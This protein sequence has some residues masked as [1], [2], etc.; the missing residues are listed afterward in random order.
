MTHVHMNF[1]VHIETVN[2]NEDI[3][4][5][6]VNN[7]DDDLSEISSDICSSDDEMPREYWDGG[8]DNEIMTDFFDD[9]DEVESAQQLGE[10]GNILQT[11]L[12]FF[13]LWASFYG[14]SATA[15]NHLIKFLHYVLSILMKNM[16]TASTF[17]TSF[18]TS[19]YMMKKYLGFS[20]DTFEK[21]VICEKC[22]S[23]YTFKEC[24]VTNSAGTCKPKA[25]N[26]IAFRN[27][28][29]PSCREPCGH[30]LLKEAT[31]RNDVKYYPRKTYCFN[32][33]QNSLINILNRKGYL[34]LCEHWRSRNICDSVLADIY[35]GCIWKEWMVYN[36]RP[37][38]ACP[39]N[40]AVMLNCDW[41]QPFDH[42]CY[43]VGVLYLVI[44]NLP[45]SLRFKPENIIITGV[46]PGPKEPNQ[47][48]MNSCLRPI[49][50]ELNALFTE[51]F[52]IEQGSK[53]H[54]IFVALIAT[55]CDLP[56]TAKLGGFLNHNSHYGCWKCC[57]FFPYVEELKRNDYSGLAVGLPR[58]HV[59]HKN[60]AKGTLLART[61]TERKKKELDVGG[62]FTE[63]FHLPY[64]NTVRYAII[65]P[66]HNLF[67]G[68][69]KRLQHYWIRMGLL[70]SCNLK[71]V[72]ERVDN[73]NTPSNIGHMP[74]KIASGFSNMTA[75][76][77]KNW[78][79]LYSVIALHD[80]LPPQHMACWQLFVSACTILCSPII[81][82]SEIDHVQQLLYEFFISVERLDSYNVTINT[83]LHL[84]YSQCLKD[85][86]PCY[87]YWL[88]S[89]ERYN[90][91]LGKYHTNRKS[92]ETQLMQTF[93]N[94]MYAKSLADDINPLHQ[95]VFENLLTS[96][97]VGAFNETVYGQEEFSASHMLKFSE[98]PV[99]PSLSYL[100]RSFIKLIPPYIIQKIENYS[101][102]YLRESYQIFLPE[103]DPFEIPQFIRRY[104]VVHWW[105][106]CLGKPKY[107]KKRDQII[108][109]FWIG[110]DG[111]I[112]V[113]AQ[114][115]CTGKVEYF[116]TQNI[117]I[118][119]SYQLV[120]MA[121]IKWLQDH[122]EKSRLP[123]PVEIWCNEMFKPHGP[124]SFMPIVRI[125]DTCVSC[126]IEINNEMVLAINPCRS[127]IF[128]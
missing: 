70:N 126:E 101:L 108:R 6:D 50:K 31:L 35:D 106:Q 123:E 110:Q 12:V 74:G 118:E 95:S 52:V 109:A 5:V 97:V 125:Y 128:L 43:S 99:T 92:I 83:H 17:F 47:A 104:E 100:D 8:S 61:P 78:T 48:M 73:F 7:D 127:K 63:L 18:P 29:Y 4:E 42:S 94:D 112:D 59:E 40:L 11:S 68:T 117:L 75:D 116:F 103:V 105:S 28:P 111:K 96:K 3:M 21:Y 25:C 93:L 82:L 23:L 37:F 113:N 121:K 60:N 14:V 90:G 20:K 64:Y 15:L 38:L 1:C 62:R 55:V 120:P 72:Q 115:L 10:K 80:I 98:G 65:D 114:S 30:H 26:H 32:S 124:A 119:D 88:F 45:R 77:W 41:F 33:I 2:D 56:A 46:I 69:S 87:G 85:Y 34:D 57:R 49:V 9:D 54:K 67:L 24:F 79:I 44:L 22:G 27:H 13:M 19:L 51:G 81:T 53:S 16:S 91:I 86:G 107:S 122:P 89:F 71:I 36:G 76:E 66:L 84:H 102:Q 39:H 58:E